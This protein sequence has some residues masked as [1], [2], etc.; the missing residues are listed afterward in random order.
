MFKIDIVFSV[1]FH[2]VLL[3]YDLLY[4]RVN[5]LFNIYVLHYFLLISRL[6][7]QIR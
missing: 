1:F 2:F 6:L 3:C 4:T 7:A 5:P